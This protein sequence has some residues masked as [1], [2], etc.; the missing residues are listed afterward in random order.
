MPP[1]KTN[2][3]WL[4]SQAWQHVNA[5]PR[6]MVRMRPYTSALRLPSRRPWCAQV[7]VV[8]EVRRIKVLRNGSAQ[9]LKTWTLA[10]GQL[11]LFACSGNRAKLKNAQKNATKNIT[12]EAMNRNMP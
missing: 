5:T 3:A 9:G 2:G 11:A 7:T 10:G 8:P 1:L 6:Q 12:S 4:Y